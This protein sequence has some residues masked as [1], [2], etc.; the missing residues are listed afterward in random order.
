LR[1]Q[2][3]ERIKKLVNNYNS[4]AREGKLSQFSE[5]DVGSKF[6]LPFLEALGWDTKNIDEVR[7]QRRTLTGPADYSLNVNR[8]PKIVIEIKKFGEKLDGF[9]VVRGR[10]ESYPQQAIR[11]AWHLK[12][13]W[14]VLTNF[15]ELRLYYSHV[16]KPEEG[17]IFKLKCNEYLEN[18]DRLWM[19][20]KE[21][22]ASGILDTYEKRRRRRNIDEEVL[23]D[24]FECRKILADSIVKNNPGLISEE[25]REHVQKLLDRILIIRVAEDRNVIGADSLWKALDTWKTRGLPTPFMRSLKGLFRDFDEIYN[26]KLFEKHKCEDLTL[27]NDSLEKVIE[28]LYKY[29]FDLISAD[30]L[31][32]IYED[33]IGHILQE[34]EMG[35]DIIKSHEIRKRKGIYYTPIHIVD[36]IVRR[37]L[38]VKLEK[39][40]REAE[41]LLNEGK[42][43]EARN[44][45]GEVSQIKVL[46]HACGSGSFLI[47]AFDVFKEYYDLYNNYVQRAAQKTVRGYGAYISDVEKKILT[48]NLYGVDLDPQATEIAAVNLMLKALKKGE[49]LPLILDENIKVGNSLISPHLE[50]SDLENFKEDFKEMLLL[51]KERRALSLL[52]PGNP[53]EKEEIDAKRA[54]YLNKERL[55]KEK[56]YRKL[57][58]K[59]EKWFN[60]PSK[61]KPFLWQ[62]EF[63]EVFFNDD[64]SIKPNPGF[65]V[66]IGNPPH[67][68]KLSESERKF[69]ADEYQTGKGYKN[70]ASLFIE[71]SENLLKSK[72]IVGLVIPKSLTFSEKWRTTRNFVLESLN[73]RE[74]TDLSKAFT[75]VLLEQVIIILEKDELQ[76]TYLG[77]EFF[78][79]EP[80]KTNE[81]PI[82]LCSETDALLIHVDEKSIPIFRKIKDRGILLKDISKTFRGLPV[83]SKAIKR[84]EPN[85]EPLLRGDDIKRYY[86]AEPQI[87][88]RE[89]D[90]DKSSKITEMK[91]PKIIS[92]RIIAHV[93]KPKDH[94]VIMSTLDEKGLLNVDTVENT[95]L[96]NDNYDMKY[97]LGLLNSKLVSWFAYLF[98][99][100]KAIRTM[101]FDNYYIGK[102]PIPP[103][104]LEQQRPIIG[105]VDKILDLNKKLKQINID[106]DVYINSVPREKDTTLEAYCTKYSKKRVPF[107]RSHIRGDIK[108]VMVEEQNDWLILKIDYVSQTKGVKES[109]ENVE[110]IKYQIEDERVRKFIAFSILNCK[111]SWGRGNILRKIQNTSIPLFSKN[112]SENHKII[113][114]LMDDYLEKFWKRKSLEKQIEVAENQINQNIYKLYGLTAEEVALIESSF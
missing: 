56:I 69:F 26:S 36:Y 45:F 70:T 42:F 1:E 59:L 31:G 22:A 7:E 108:K 41:K 68:A 34:V 21:S 88:I 39:I 65:T 109:H 77:V 81:I 57:N 64:G 50:K 104:T 24:L 90:L 92:Q 14:V 17:L 113:V 86:H 40:W 43:E 53:Q 9:R 82:Y 105:L 63:P 38:G 5:S 27:D 6:I 80:P 99:F 97:V 16:I 78:E 110:V 61:V 44:K 91:R 46:D 60:N 84:R 47:K 54:E 30:V 19:L 51:K 93:L 25:I 23:G 58:P 55:I 13:D 100:N 94:I 107:L 18:F 49:R 106:F 102:I 87:F 101:D 3:K 28:I 112:Q 15:E 12:V 83:Q 33:Y 67:G 71:R 96:T 66:I 73:I 2:A 48:E 85:S 89:T 75:G 76:Q 114:K 11:Y 74:I 103:A 29:N 98:I 52:V 79:E 95:I 4:L 35:I 32:A 8:R 37:T 62:V 20:S 111:K 72:G 10:E